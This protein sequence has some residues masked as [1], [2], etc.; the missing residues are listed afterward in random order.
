MRRPRSTLPISLKPWQ[1]KDTSAVLCHK[2]VTSGRAEN[3]PHMRFT[4]AVAYPPGPAT[5]LGRR[6][7]WARMTDY[8]SFYAG[9]LTKAFLLPRFDTVVT[10]TT[11]PIIGLVGTLLKSLRSTR[12]IYWSMDLHPDAS[13][14]LGRMKADRLFRDS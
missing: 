3:R 10:L 14:A 13:M 12:H 9:A 1:S 7:T 2:G 6:G 8:L 5:S 4:R 11:P